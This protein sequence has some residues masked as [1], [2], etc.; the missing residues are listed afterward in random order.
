MGLAVNPKSR[1]DETK[2][3]G[4]L[5]KISED[6]PTFRLDRD[7]QTKELVITGMS[8]LHLNVIQERLARRAVT[9][10][11]LCQ[12]QTVRNRSSEEQFGDLDRV[13]GSALAHVVGHHPHTHAARMG[14]VPPQPADEN[15]I[16]ARRM[17][18]HDIR[19]A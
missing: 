16:G 12:A 10:N 17:Q 5:S 4:A 15:R 3:S 18:R 2:L 14:E 1:G 9:A 13:E 19:L 7:A 8:E 11:G 6:D